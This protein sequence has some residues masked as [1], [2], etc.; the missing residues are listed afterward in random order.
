MFFI[1]YDAFIGA[2]INLRQKGTVDKISSNRLI[3]RQI[4]DVEKNP[5]KI[6]S[7]DIPI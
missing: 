5:F 4:G 6:G 7:K 2:E 3:F 1:V